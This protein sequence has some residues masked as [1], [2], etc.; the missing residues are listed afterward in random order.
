MPSAIPQ[1]IAFWGSSLLALEMAAALSRAGTEAIIV[2][3][4][5]HDR[6]RL[7][8]ILSRARAHVAL[9]ADFPA[10]PYDLIFDAGT[11][12]LR[13]FPPAPLATLSPARTIPQAL[14]VDLHHLP[15][16]PPLLEVGLPKP[17]SDLSG[18]SNA[19]G[20]SLALRQGTGPSP[21]ARL[22]NALWRAA[23]D[24]LLNGATLWEIDEDLEAAGFAIGPYAAQDI[25]GL[26][27]ALILRKLLSPHCK[28]PIT[29]RAYAE[30]RIGRA[31]GWGW[32]RYPGGGGRVIDPLTEDM[33]TEEARFAGITP[34]NRPMPEI[35]AALLAAIQS[36][37]RALT[38]EGVSPE[39]IRLAASLALGC[40]ASL[41]PL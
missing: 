41:L 31:L 5:P 4:D 27:W 9:H 3:P 10:L 39:T 34:E 16:L 7:S 1:R 20:A 25:C 33:A 30:G 12:P 32:Y 18:L 17:G 29:P 26:E 15:G 2:E 36:E 37:A 22:Q 21:G 11:L 28:N 14:A 19:L 13:P 35:R 38:S 6:E 23:D 24:A 40:P 8:A